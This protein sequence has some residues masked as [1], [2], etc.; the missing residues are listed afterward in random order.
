MASIGARAH[1][2][3]RG[4]AAFIADAAARAGASCL[5]LAPAKALSDCPAPPAPMEGAWAR[6]VS[7]ALASR[8]VSV[9]V[10][11]CYVDL[12]APGEAS[13]REA[14]ERLSHNL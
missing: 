11:G 6:A 14:V 5:Q 8:G 3:G 13:R 4:D 7:A 1:D 10:R 2:L 12:C 9:A